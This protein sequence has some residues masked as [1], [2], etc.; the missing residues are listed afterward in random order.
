MTDSSSSDSESD[1][2]GG[3]GDEDHVAVGLV[4]DVVVARA[5]PIRVALRCDVCGEYSDNVM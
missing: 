3:A 2:V 5:R 4:E 1:E